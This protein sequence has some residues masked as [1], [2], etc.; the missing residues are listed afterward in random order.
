MIKLYRYADHWII[1]ED[2]ELFGVTVHKGF[3]TDGASVP[4]VAWW[5][6]HPSG[7]AFE[8]AIVHD[9]RISH[10]GKQGKEIHV[11]FYRNLR[12]SGIGRLRSSVAYLFVRWFGKWVEFKQSRE[13][14]SNNQG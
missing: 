11:E 7:M 2:V 10:E 9:Y 1:M 14:S 12:S 6:M 13:Y 8:A 3:A 4:K 5:F